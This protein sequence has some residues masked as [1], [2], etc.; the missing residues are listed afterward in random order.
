MGV[1]TASR[2]TAKNQLPSQ[3]MIKHSWERLIVFKI[4]GTIK[5]QSIEINKHAFSSPELLYGLPQ[6]DACAHLDCDVTKCGDGRDNACVTP[7]STR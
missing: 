3:R 4:R 7:R 1:A 2:R 5:M 6:P